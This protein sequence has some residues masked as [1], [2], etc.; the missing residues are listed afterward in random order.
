MD[1]V[2]VTEDLTKRYGKIT[3][4][5]KLT[6]RVKEGTIHGFLGPNGAGKTTTIKLLAYSSPMAGGLCCSGRA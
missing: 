3:A 1:Y 2:I 6:L 4:L 5:D